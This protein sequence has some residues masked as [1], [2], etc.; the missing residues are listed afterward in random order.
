MPKFKDNYSGVVLEFEGKW[1]VDQ[2][3]LHPDYTEVVEEKEQDNK[4]NK[5]LT[6]PKKD[7]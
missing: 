7:K 2:M 4:D 1:D 6:L 5:T 3:R